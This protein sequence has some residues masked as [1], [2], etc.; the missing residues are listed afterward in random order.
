M[1]VL[2]ISC[3]HYDIFCERLTFRGVNM[4]EASTIRTASTRVSD[5]SVSSAGVQ[6]VS[7]RSCKYFSKQ[8]WAN[9]RIE[10]AVEERM[11]T[12]LNVWTTR[13]SN[14][15]QPP[16]SLLRYAQS[17]AYAIVSTNTCNPTQ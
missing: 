9:H 17:A 8:A 5:A 11:I 13:C 2:S 16:S 14:Q 1:V 4:A 12:A 3:L 7:C 15:P 6:I 10:H